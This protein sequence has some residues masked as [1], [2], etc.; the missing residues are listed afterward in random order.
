MTFLLHRAQPS[1]ARTSSRLFSTTPASRLAKITVVGRLAAT[2]EVITTSS[3]QEIIRYA[4]GT[5]HGRG[6]KQ[7]T[8]W[9]KVANFPRDEQQ[10]DRMLNLTVG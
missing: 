1:L 4:V 7:S 5:N 2:P 3:G 8:S 6:E 10:K 9:W